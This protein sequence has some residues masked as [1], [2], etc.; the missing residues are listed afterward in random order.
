MRH[1]QI[2]VMDQK[3]CFKSYK[4]VDSKN[5]IS[6]WYVFLLCTFYVCVYIYGK[7]GGLSLLEQSLRKCFEW[8][9]NP[10]IHCPIIG[11]LIL[12]GAELSTASLKDVKCVNYIQGLIIT[13]I[14]LKTNLFDHRVQYIFVAIWKQKSWYCSFWKYS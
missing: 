3:Q 7:I 1:S 4:Y 12:L 6:I 10:L 14:I 8:P 11:L 5:Q 2:E 13:L 9:L